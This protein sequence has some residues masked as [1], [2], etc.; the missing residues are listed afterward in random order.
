MKHT[1]ISY[2]GQQSPLLQSDPWFSLFNK[3]NHNIIII[4]I[5]QIKS[6]W[7][8]STTFVDAVANDGWL[9]FSNLDQGFIQN[10]LLGGE[11]EQHV[12]TCWTTK[13]RGVW[14]MVHPHQK[15]VYY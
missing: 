6:R 14:G 1:I 3:L 7:F 15:N 10:V 2:S 13:P 4:I 12:S 11:G 5:M 9:P 8:L